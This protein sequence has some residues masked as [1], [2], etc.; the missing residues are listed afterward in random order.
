M[1]MTNLAD[2]VTPVAALAEVTLGNGIRLRYVHQGPATGRAVILLH[3][4]SD[5]SFSFSRIMPLL[6]Q[7]LRVIAPDL[8]GHGDSDKPSS[9][10]RMVDLADDVIQLMGRLDVPSAVIVGHSLGSFVAQAIGERVPQLVTGLVLVGSAPVA[11]NDVFAELLLAVDALSDPVDP[12]FVRDFQYSTIAN[13]VPQA[14]MDEAIA[15]SRRVPASVWKQLIRGQMEFTPQTPRSNARV[16]IVGGTR[17]AV[18]SVTE[19]T[20]LAQQYPLARLRLLDGVGHAVHWE[21]PE[22]FVNA[23]IRFVR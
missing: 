2:T 20:R 21:Q 9:G 16:L 4:Y 3:G 5:S 22:A 19:Q 10:Y 12:T 15:I 14:F 7:E 11:R 1:N 23:I 6:P 8:R 13:P 18:F 17:D